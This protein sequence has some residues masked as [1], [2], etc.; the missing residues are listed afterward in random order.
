MAKLCN[1]VPIFSLS[2]TRTQFSNSLKA[3]L[4]NIFPEVGG[5]GVARVR[6]YGMD[7]VLEDQLLLR[8]F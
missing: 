8:F 4:R 2:L 3:F 6:V 1:L 5:G 7:A